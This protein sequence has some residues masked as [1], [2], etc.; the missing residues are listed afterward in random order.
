MVW[1]VPTLT[2]MYVKETPQHVVY[3][4]LYTCTDYPSRCEQSLLYLASKQFTTER[5]V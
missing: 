4:E 3:V 5:L 1:H 2:P